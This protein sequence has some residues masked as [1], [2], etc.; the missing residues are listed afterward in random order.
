MRPMRS[1]SPRISPLQ[2][3]FTSFPDAVRYIGGHMSRVRDVSNPDGDRRDQL[4][5]R[6]RQALAVSISAELI[7]VDQHEADR[8]LRFTARHAAPAGADT[9]GGDIDLDLP[10]FFDDE[11]NQAGGETSPS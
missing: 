1:R 3:I 10:A 6:L 8:Q 2:V 11:G 4:S 7:R 5:V 9:G